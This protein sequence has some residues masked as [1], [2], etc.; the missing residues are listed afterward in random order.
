MEKQRT[1]WSAGID[2]WVGCSSTFRELGVT[3]E[4]STL[5]WVILMRENRTFSNSLIVA[6]TALF[7]ILSVPGCQ[8]TSIYG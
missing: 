2:L 4:I 3:F 6:D 8:R 7:S 1:V 5:T